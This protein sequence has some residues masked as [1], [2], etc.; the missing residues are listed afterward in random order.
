MTLICVFS[1]QM[2]LPA[3]VFMGLEQDDCCGCGGHEDCGK[4]CA[5]GFPEPGGEV[6]P[7]R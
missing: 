3:F 6:A 5:V 1:K 2:L 7:K 4:R